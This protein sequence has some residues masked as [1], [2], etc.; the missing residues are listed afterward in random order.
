MRLGILTFHSQLNYGGVLQCWALQQAL[1]RLLS[2]ELRVKSEE[3]EVMVV[4]R[5][6]SPDNRMLDGPFGHAGF[7]GWC[8]IALKSLLGCG[9][10]KQVL[11]HWRTRWFVKSLNLTPYHF[12]NWSDLTSQPQP[13]NL[14]LDMLVVGSDQVWHCGDWGNPRPYLLEGA[15]GINAI[16]YA[17]SFGMAAI[18]TDQIELYK[19]GLGR[20]AALSCRE[21]EGAE[22]CRGLG[23]EATHVVD[24]TLLI[25][26]SEWHKFAGNR[27]IRT[28]EQSNNH[29]LVCYFM[30]VDM[31]AELSLLEN[32][33]EKKNCTVELL[34]NESF[35]RPIP[36]SFRQL[37][38]NFRYTRIKICRGY[39]PKEFVR[40]FSSA[41]WV[42][43]DSFHAVMFSSI[44]N[45]N[46]RFLRPANAMRR[47]MFA[48]VEEFAK[49]CITGG[50]FVDD[51][52]DALRSLE[53]GE[54]ITFD[55]NR[56]AVM[57]AE[58][59]KWLENAII[60]SLPNFHA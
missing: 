38:S 29:K 53:Q 6:L 27:T 14:N 10:W 39:G 30:S 41:S 19:R 24:P 50:F 59:M 33:A 45:C 34:A 55:A 16:S 58:S 8:V 26:P 51:V 11:R 12:C 2:E 57:R 44:F 18:P 25:D 1:T 3:C 48:R 43:T 54:T 21:K 22:I 20:F 42:L 15:P 32:F 47:G 31:A 56:I 9:T 17:A 52:E 5:W 60:Y 40:A 36:K 13:F 23:Y 46:A 49:G 35:L 4:D 7:K 37:L 28:I